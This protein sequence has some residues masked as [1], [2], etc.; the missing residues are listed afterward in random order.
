MSDLLWYTAFT[1]LWSPYERILHCERKPS[2]KIMLKSC[3]HFFSFLSSL[4]HPT[5]LTIP[6]LVLWLNTRCS[7]LNNFNHTYIGFMIKYN[8]VSFYE[9][10]VL[11]RQ[12]IKEKKALQRHVFHSFFGYGKTEIT[13]NTVI[14]LSSSIYTT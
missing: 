10:K 1:W 2:N 14:V 4:I 5:T 11:Q 6:I 12:C 13:T 8:V 3:F 9:W 7:L